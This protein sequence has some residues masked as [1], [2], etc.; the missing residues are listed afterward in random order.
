MLIKTSIVVA[1][2]PQVPRKILKNK[3]SILLVDIEDEKKAQGIATLSAF[4]IGV[5]TGIRTPVTAVKVF[6][7]RKG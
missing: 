3:S 4:L 5:P 2:V 6:S 7:I 1:Y